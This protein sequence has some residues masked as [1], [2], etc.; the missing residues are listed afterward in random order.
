MTSDRRAFLKATL[1]GTLA[2]AGSSQ[3]RQRSSSDGSFPQASARSSRPTPRKPAKMPYKRIATEEAWISSE[4]AEGYRKLLASRSLNDPGFEAQWGGYLNNTSRLVERL[5]DIGD[6]RIRDMDAAGIDVQ[7]LS[8]T[9]PGVQVFD[10]DTA[11]RLAAA[12]N[13]QVAEAVRKYPERFR[14]LAAVASQDPKE[15]AR[16]IQ[17]ARQQLHLNGVIIN[18]HTMGEY[19]DDNKFWDIFEAAEAHNM[20]IYLHPQ[21]PSPA[22][23]KP[24]LDRGLERA[25]LGFAHEVSVHLLGI[26]TSGVFD[27]FPQLKI[28]IGH[29]GEGLPFMMYRIDY[30]YL[31]VRIKRPKTQL[32]PSD[33]IRRN[34][35]VTSSGLAYAPSI[36]FAQREL[37]MDRVLYAMDYPYQYDID[38]VHYSDAFPIS[39]AE[40]KMF[41][42]SNAER[43][44]RL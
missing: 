15:A 44:F 38:E 20:P 8:L 34:V 31:N 19:L 1:V 41:F 37:G 36:T 6:A 7:V 29:G 32:K 4:T 25:I 16:E 17:R 3:A 42:Q 18:S 5:L 35:F 33:Y 10:A 40:K 14:A 26:I 23:I 27:R 24:Y 9:A 30:M 39:P 28:V 43:V 11:K 21:T 12:S 2:G 22:M 13:D